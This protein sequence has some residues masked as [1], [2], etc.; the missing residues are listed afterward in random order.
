[1]NRSSGA[2]PTKRARTYPYTFICAGSCAYAYAHSGCAAH[3]ACAHSLIMGRVKCTAVSSSR[4]RRGG[5]GGRGGTAEM[6]TFIP[7]TLSFI[8]LL[9]GGSEEGLRRGA[10]LHQHL[11]GHAA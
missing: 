8:L 11:R 6:N 2:L 10:H 7:C 4:L 3:Y 9:L 1:M 5:Q